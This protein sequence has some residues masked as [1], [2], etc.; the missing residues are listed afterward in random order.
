[1]DDSALTAITG[2]ANIMTTS[3]T[4]EPRPRRTRIAHLSDVHLLEHAPSWRVPWLALRTRFLSFGRRLDPNGREQKLRRAL[5]C[6]VNAGADHFVFSGDLTEVGTMPQFERFAEVLHDSGIAPE[7]I[8][9]VPGNHDSYTDP[10]AWSRAIEGPLAAFGRTSAR[11]RTDVVEAAGVMLLPINVTVHQPVTRSAGE[12]ADRDADRIERLLAD[13]RFRGR[14]VVVV[15]HHPP[16]PHRMRAWQWIDGLRGWPR[17]MRLFAQHPAL[18]LLHGH[19]HRV[20]DELLG[21]RRIRVFGAPAV[22]EE[23]DSVPRIR[24]YE[25]NDG[26]LESVG[27]LAA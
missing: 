22:V 20:V 23:V 27:I 5:R 24:L 7:R 21:D 11:D 19:Q 3:P 4:R 13:A 12:L 25:V 14:P 8:T 18:Q 10:N 26:A 9:L 1:M 2:T 17:L 6:A 16:M 15:Q